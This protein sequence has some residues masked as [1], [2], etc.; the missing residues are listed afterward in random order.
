MTARIDN[1]PPAR[2]DVAVEG[3]EAWRNTNDFVVAWANPPEG[4]RAPIT[5]AG[6]KLCPAGAGSCTRGQQAGSDLSRFGVAA[7]APGEWTVSLWRRDAA[8]NETEAAASVPV[9]L[10]YDPEPPQLGFESPVAADPTLVAVAV[11]DRVSGLAR[12]SIEISA[13]GSGVWQALPTADVGKPTGGP[14]RRRCAS[15]GRLR[16]CERAPP[17]R[18]A[19]RRRRI[20]GLTASP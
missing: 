15:R 19:T 12:G 5:G 1:T 4:D 10:R 6:Y 17:T 8:G 9:A 7:P 13:S 16:R 20:A 14:H 2:V 3:G 11:T 18:R